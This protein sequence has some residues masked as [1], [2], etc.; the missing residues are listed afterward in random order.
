MAVIKTTV[1]EEMDK[2]ITPKIAT[3]TGT[4]I[5]NSTKEDQNVLSKEK[6]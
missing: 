6:N 2:Y 3:D 1:K 5:T 4:F